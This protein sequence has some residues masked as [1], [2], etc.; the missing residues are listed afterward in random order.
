MAEVFTELGGEVT[1]QGA[2]NVGDTDMRPILTEIASNAPDVLYFPN[3]EPE[4]PLM[5][6]QSAEISGLENT[7]LFSADGALVDAFPENAGAP[8]EGMYMSG[9]Y[10]VPE[11]LYSELLEKWED[12]IGGVPPSGFHAHAYDGANMLMDAIEAVAKVDEE[13]NLLIGRQ[14]IR[15]YLSSITGYTGAIGQ[16]SCGPTGDCATGEALGVYQITDAEI[17]DGVWPPEV[18]YTP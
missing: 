2:I 4:V 15:D 7:I 9:P 16:I 10:I 18:I 17:S 12:Q 5:V 6:A 14:A 3:F 1:F 11:G 13:G 8:A